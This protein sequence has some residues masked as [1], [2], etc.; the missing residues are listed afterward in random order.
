MSKLCRAANDQAQL[1]C[2]E[3]SRLTGYSSDHISLMLRK[4][5]I[6]GQKRGRDWFLNAKSLYEYVQKDPHP[7]RKKR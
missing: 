2:S 4:G 7:G 3:A 6:N 5:T 1:T